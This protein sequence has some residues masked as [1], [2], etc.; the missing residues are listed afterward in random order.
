[1]TTQPK[2]SGAH[3]FVADM[4]ASLA[5]YRRLGLTIEHGGGDH[6]ARAVAPDGSSG[7]QLGSYAL[8]RGYNP[9][10]QTPGAVAKSTLNF[11][12]DSRA[13][14]DALYAEFTSS[15]DHGSLAPIDAFWGS[16]FAV[17][18]DPDGNEV[19]LQS[20]QDRARAIKPPV[21]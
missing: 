10:W 12:L 6:F 7:L 9:N 11:E 4:H 21:E 18:L 8:T 15:G 20:P 17:I 16:R 2:F 19:C 5:F 3:L 1:M 14:V 13:A